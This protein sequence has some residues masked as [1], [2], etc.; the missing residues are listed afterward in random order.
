MPV[1]ELK[2]HRPERCNRSNPEEITRPGRKK[3]AT[4]KSLA[5]LYLNN[6]YQTI[7]RY[8]RKIYFTPYCSRE[9]IASERRHWGQS[10]RPGYAS[11]T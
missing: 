3:D 9:Q 8:Q 4:D 11:H 6:R 2:L 7:C 5:Q 1:I 10:L